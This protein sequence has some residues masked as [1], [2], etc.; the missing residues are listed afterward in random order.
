MAPD[1]VAIHDGARPLVSDAI[2]TDSLR[3]CRESG[4]ALAAVPA[5]DT[6][7]LLGEDRVVCA[8]LDR[9]QVYLAQTPQSFR[10]D[11]IC[12]AHE[13]AE[14]EGWQVTDDAALVERLGHP[15]RISQ[16]DP[17]N[18]KVTVPEDLRYAEW[19]LSGG[20]TPALRVGH[21]WDLHRLAAGRPL[22]LGGVHVE[23]DM[24]LLGHSDADAALHA[25]CDAILG[26]CALGDIGRHFPDTDP[27]YA[28][29]DS[30]DLTRRVVALA[31]AAGWRVGNVDVT[32]V[33]QAPR[34][35]PHIEAMRQATAEA[36][37]VAVGAV[38]YKAKTAEG[39]GPV[40]REEAIAAEAVV[41]MV[42]AI[43]DQR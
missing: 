7:K 28:G 40:G 39:L 2:I 26:A 38:S 11:L 8:T 10:Y 30:R 31:Q 37:G 17:T 21:G 32:I 24:G 14:R 35:A 22:V 6:V 16:G 34:L 42:A 36:L 15:V 12:R 19:L 1:L 25:V 27:A 3:V 41:S 4:A 13:Q 5:G 23:H 20:G 18:L 29:A 33:A 9:R 43:G